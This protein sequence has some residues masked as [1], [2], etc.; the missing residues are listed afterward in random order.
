MIT[1]VHDFTSEKYYK[2]VPRKDRQLFK[3]YD[4]M[5]VGNRMLML[6]GPSAKDRNKAKAS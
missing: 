4:F 1:N 3:L 5:M 2:Y 6:A